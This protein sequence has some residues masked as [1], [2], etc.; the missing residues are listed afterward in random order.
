MPLT[1]DTDNPRRRADALRNID[2]ILEAA[3]RCLC[4]DPEASIADIA[5]AAGVGRVTLYGHF[6]SRAELIDVVVQRAL[7]AFDRAM[8]AI[9]LTGDPR[10]ALV[11]LVE[12]TWHLTAESALLVVAAERSLP[13]A[14]LWSAHQG[15]AQRVTELI[16]RGQAQRVFRTDLSASWLVS[17]FHGVVH[18]GANEV[19]AGRVDAAGAGRLI[20]ATLLAAFTA[21]D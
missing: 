14:R 15:P 8:E 16:E 5:S 2:A 11:R 7:E 10:E 21:S 9:D 4:R 3:R 17:V 12:E 20:A 18:T 6:S 19:A 13:S 1:P